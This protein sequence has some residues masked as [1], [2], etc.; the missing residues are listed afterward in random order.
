M[1]NYK[2]LVPIILVALFLLG[3]YMKFDKNTGVLEEYKTY[4]DAARNYRELGIS[5]DAESNYLEAIEV[6]PNLELY[7]EIGEFYQECVGPRSAI[8]WVEE[9]VELYPEEVKSYEFALGLYKELD[10]Y[11]DFFEL[12]E[13]V[14]KRGLTS[15]TIASYVNDLKAKYYLDGDYEDVGFYADGYCK[16][17]DDGYWAY[18]SKKGKEVTKFN[19]VQAG[20][21]CDGV[22]PV[23]NKIGEK[24]F[25]DYDGNKKYVI[26]NVDN[27]VDIGSFD[28]E[29]CTIY[30]GSSWG[31]Y[32]L[33][34]ELL[35]GGYSNISALGNG[36]VAVENKGKWSLLD[37]DGESL[38]EASF[39]S[40][41][42]DEKGI[43]YRNGRVF[44]EK[45]GK[46]GMMDLEGKQITSDTYEDVKI[47]NGDG[48][49][50]VKVNGKWGFINKD[51]EVVIKPQYE[52]ARSFSNGY[53]AVKKNKT[54]GFI[55]ANN[56][57]FI[58]YMFSEVKDFTNSGSVFVKI[59]TWKLLRLYSYN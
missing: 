27:I 51:G 37:Y 17:Y 55:D 25:S 28:E 9:I 47:F 13:T 2:N 23:E 29:V 56:E 3:I 11:E 32:T 1:K 6:K 4:L 21:F 44:V 8:S 15:E 43:V 7:I 53:A 30:D 57:I 42:S 18:V 34:G 45:N 14:E 39:D 54:W 24:F 31:V 38:I 35:H 49:A 59:G 5:V 52:D 33:K 12:Y 46:Y 40:V 19:F 20:N 41:K 16:V 48:Y 10:R 26:E 58:D 22:A 36:V 50:A